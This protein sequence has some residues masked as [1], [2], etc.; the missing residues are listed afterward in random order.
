[1]LGNFSEIEILEGNLAVMHTVRTL[2]K[3]YARFSNDEN[4][5]E[6]NFIKS[7]GIV[8]MVSIKVEW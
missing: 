6:N 7:D 5:S 2:A 1:M 4:T 3:K 8:L